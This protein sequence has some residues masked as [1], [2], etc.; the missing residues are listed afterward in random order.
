M[1]V[2]VILRFTICVKRKIREW[3]SFLFSVILSEKS[4]WF[5]WLNV[6]SLELWESGVKL[7]SQWSQ[8]R[9]QVNLDSEK[10]LVKFTYI[11]FKHYCTRVH[12][13]Q[14]CFFLGHPLRKRKISYKSYK[15]NYCNFTW[16]WGSLMAK[17]RSNF[18]THIGREKRDELS[19]LVRFF[20]KLNNTILLSSQC[21][22][23]RTN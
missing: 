18:K 23:V 21:K 7:K 15:I 1:R 13:W 11:H 6:K 10:C 5:G 8:F 20:A 16:N 4:K 2:N 19:V 3:Q 17:S 9:T 22:K 14:K 12:L